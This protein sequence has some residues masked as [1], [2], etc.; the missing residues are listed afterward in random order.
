MKAKKN[1]L[2]GWELLEQQWRTKIEQKEEALPDALWNKL[3]QRL[4]AQETKKKGGFISF[5]TLRWA[6]ASVILLLGMF[7][8]QQNSAPELAP[9]MATKEE[10]NKLPS[11]GL[12]VAKQAIGFQKE[13]EPAPTQNEQAKAKVQHLQVIETVAKAPIQKEEEVD[14]RATVV[15]EVQLDVAKLPEN[16]QEA[17]PELV[18]KRAEPL[19]AEE[20]FVIVDVEPVKKEKGI[21]KVISFFQKVKTGKV[22]E[23]AN[24]PREGK[25]N[26]GIHQVVYKIQEKEEKIKTMLSL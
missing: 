20:L 10:P 1:P 9:A 3:E 2:T 21:Q 19:P 13:A 17:K 22:F 8:M 5:T 14:N 24:K 12:E 11:Q 4:D 26:D 7:W 25:M 18:A 23:L 15:R 16:V 6:A